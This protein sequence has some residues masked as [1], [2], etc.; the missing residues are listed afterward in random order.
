MADEATGRERRS[1][2]KPSLV[3]IELAAEEVLSTGCK[4]SLT[5]IGRNNTFMCSNPL[6]AGYLGS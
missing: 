5:S 4:T 6:C 3:V 1:Y 2:E